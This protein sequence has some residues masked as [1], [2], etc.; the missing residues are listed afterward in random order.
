[1]SMFENKTKPELERGNFIAYADEPNAVV[2]GSGGG[3]GAVF[4]EADYVD[5]ESPLEPKFSFND[6]KNALDA[7]KVVFIKYVIDGVPVST[8]YKLVYSV[9]V[10]ETPGDESYI[11]SAVEG[12]TTYIFSATDPNATMTDDSH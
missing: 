11:V 6:V 2:S 7:G 5:R 10:D 9:A 1:M 8:N 4:L 12:A 3:G